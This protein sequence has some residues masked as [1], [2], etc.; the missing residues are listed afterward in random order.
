M[1][2]IS[3]RASSRRRTFLAGLGRRTVSE[4]PIERSIGGRAEIPGRDDDR[5]GG[6]CGSGQRRAGNQ[7]NAAQND[8]TA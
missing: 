6:L 8:A 2:A 3:V 1:T 7:A 4:Q 5:T